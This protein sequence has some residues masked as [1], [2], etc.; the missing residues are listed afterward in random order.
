M[1]NAATRRSTSPRSKE[2]PVGVSAYPPAASSSE[3]PAIPEGVK[4][5]SYPLTDA[6]AAE[7]LAALHGDKLR[8]DHKRERWLI[9]RGHWWDIDRDDELIRLAIDVAR[10]RHCAAIRIPDERARVAM[11]KHARSCETMP[12]VKRTWETAQAL[13]PFAD[14]GEGWDANPWLL[15]VRNGVVDLRT[16]KLRA[17]SPSDRITR[18]IEIDFDP[19]AL[20]PRWIRFLDE[21]FGG[22]AALIDFVHRAVGYSL[23]GTTTEQV[24]FLCHGQGSNGKSVFLRLMRLILGPYACDT[25]FST[26]ELAARATIPNDVAALEGKRLVTAAETNESARFN[27]ARIK[28]LTGGDAVTARFLN[29]EF[30]SFEPTFKIWFSVNHKPKVADDSYAFWRRIRLIPFLTQ[31]KLASEAV[32]GEPVMDKHLY[33]PLVKEAAGIL[34]W[35]IRGAVAWLNNGLEPPA[36]VWNATV[37]YEAE[38]DPLQTFLDETC[39][40]GPVFQVGAGD[41][42]GE[43]R[44]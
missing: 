39:V 19:D 8:F 21:V 41:N 28:A 18:H 13:K 38:N 10:I 24:L 16:G 7:L 6:G 35:A 31:F 32:P 12:I 20:C 29:H 22:D 40:L 15:G 26:F 1:P 17:G 23:T 44:R 11:V 33:E 34:A 14:L 5:E 30:F 3:I 4:P 9:W 2:S 42:G 27:E 36:V 25:P 43:I 37:A